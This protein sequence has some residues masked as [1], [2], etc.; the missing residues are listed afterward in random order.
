MKIIILSDT[1]DLL[2]PE[3]LALLPGCDCILHGGDISSQG[4]L[5]QLRQYAPVRAVRG[6]NDR[7]WA[8]GLPP[9]LDF[10]IAGLRVYMTH[11]K[12][13]LPRDLSPYDLVVIGHSHQYSGTWMD[14]PGASGRTLLLNPG[15]CGPRRFHQPVTLAVLTVTE[16]GWHVDR[17]DL[18]H[19]LRESAPKIDPGNVRKQIEIVMKETAKGTGVAAIAGKYGMEEALV[20]QIARLYVTHPGVTA[21]GIMTKMGL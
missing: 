18:P 4:I 15:S 17:V 8:E 21:D 20:E 5:D 3:V 14:R 12:K 6:N 9:F 13:D 19:S 1:H 11:K 7:D 2:R 10:E 16:D